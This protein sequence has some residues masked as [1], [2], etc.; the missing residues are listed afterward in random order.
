MLGVIP[1][2]LVLLLMAGALLIFPQIALFLPA[3]L[4]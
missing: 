2:A 1:Y 3:F 4:S